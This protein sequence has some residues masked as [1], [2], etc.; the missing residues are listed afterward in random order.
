MRPRTGGND[1]TL[2][3]DVKHSVFSVVEENCE[4]ARLD[5]QA[6]EKSGRVIK[7]N[8]ALVLK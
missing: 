3:G 4:W 8:D 1:K 6:C 2:L 7:E 5:T